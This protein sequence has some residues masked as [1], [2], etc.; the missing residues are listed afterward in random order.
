M[1]RQAIIQKQLDLVKLRE[2]N[3]KLW[4]KMISP[5]KYYNRCRLCWRQR[6]YIREFW[7]C[8]VCFR[9][10]AR[11]WLIMWVKKASW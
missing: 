10:Y 1:A 8:R 6:S 2:K 7:V 5:T 4:K 9:N 3:L 11:E